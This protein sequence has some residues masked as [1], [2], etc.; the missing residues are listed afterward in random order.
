MHFERTDIC[1][2]YQATGC[3]ASWNSW[4]CEAAKTLDLTFMGNG[5]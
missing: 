1:V 2:G 4:K 3:Y 5:L